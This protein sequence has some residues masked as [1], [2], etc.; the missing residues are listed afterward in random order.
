[1]FLE[2]KELVNKCLAIDDPSFSDSLAGGE[3]GAIFLPTSFYDTK[4]VFTT[5]SCGTKNTQSVSLKTGL[6]KVKQRLFTS[7]GSRLPFNL[8]VS[9]NQE[10][11]NKLAVWDNVSPLIAPG[12]KFNYQQSVKIVDGFAYYCDGDFNL[13]KLQPTA[14][15]Y[16][17]KETGLILTVKRIGDLLDGYEITDGQ[18]TKLI[19]NFNG[20]LT[21]IQTKNST[22]TI[23]TTIS[24]NINGK[25]IKVIDG[26]GKVY[27]FTFSS[28]LP[29]IVKAHTVP[30]SGLLIVTAVLE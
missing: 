18:N 19:F 26:L 10:Y 8:S 17:E 16:F 27:T 5:N 25:I 13:H 28:P 6:L 3:G 22:V 24:Y 2:T 14:D 12:W 11:G 23:T 1:M 7:E 9:Y 29:A 15:K 30:C 21:S 4:E 20:N